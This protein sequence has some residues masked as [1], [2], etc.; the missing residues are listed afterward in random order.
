MFI[1]A[2]ISFEN[3]CRKEHR[4]CQIMNEAECYGHDMLN[5]QYTKIE[6]SF[7]AAKYISPSLEVIKKFDRPKEENFPNAKFIWSLGC[8]RFHM[9]RL[10]TPKEGVKK[11]EAA[12]ICDNLFDVWLNGRQIASDV[13]YMELCD[14]TSALC[15]GENNLHI[16]AYQSETFD[17]FCSAF[18]GGLR[19]TY[20]NGEI[21]EILTDSSFKQVSLVTFGDT[22]EPEGFETAIGGRVSN[23][24]ESDIHPIALRRSFYYMRR[25]KL[26]EMP[27]SAT[28]YTTALGCHEPYI[29]GK[30]VSD[31]FFEP[32]CTNYQHEYSQYDMLPF[33]N[34][35]ENTIGAIL[36]NGSYNCYSWGTLYWRTPELLAELI[37]EYSDGSVERIATDESWKCLPSPLTDNDIQYGER[38]DARLEVPEW[39]TN[40]FELSN[41]FEVS[42]RE[43]ADKLLLKSYPPIKAV[44]EY[45][46]T[47][48][49]MFDGQPLYDV[50]VCIAG[51]AK[52]V[53]KDLKAG[54]QV[55]IRYY[56]RFD[57]SGKLENGAYG[58]VI[59]NNDTNLDARC[60]GFV[61]NVDMYTAKGCGV[62]SYECRF[63]YTGFRYVVLEG[64]SVDQVVSLTAFELRNDLE[65]VGSI[66]T[67]DVAVNRIFNAAKRSWLNN[68]SNGPTDCPTREKNYWNGDSQLFVNAACWM[69]DNSDFLARWTDN[70]IKM[71]DG[72]YA[73]E[74]ET[75]VIPY[76][77][78]RF[79][80][81]KEILRARYP[82]M[83]KLIEK[84]Q[85]HEEMILPKNG[86]SHQYN[87]WLSPGGV[88]PNTEFF[89]GCWYIH[90]L[91]C[92][93]EIASILGDDAKADELS[94]RAEISIEEFNRRHIEENDYDAHCQCGIVLP[95]AFGIAPEEKRQALADRLSEYVREADYHTTTGFIGAR[96][97]FEVLSDYGHTDDAYRILTNPTDPSWLGMLNSGATAITESWYGASDPDRGISMSHFSLGAVAGWFFEYLGGIRVNESAPGLER[98]VLRPVMI[99]EIGHF[100]VNYKTSRGVI[101]T[102]WKFVDSK[103]EFHYSL[104]EGVEATVIL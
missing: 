94:K 2:D 88:T 57:R 100:A 36:G 78:Y 85:E 62:E 13:R 84:R 64:L 92:I 40:A 69:T 47:E 86:I 4:L 41:A 17:S 99:P 83:L 28:L 79:Y 65:M 59:Y 60:R 63:A 75:Y 71:H 7:D 54:Q 38:Y 51:R 32:F 70:G 102:E 91:K 20:E 3:H 81:D 90:M 103:P 61:R 104:P 74:D 82:K 67:D 6:R 8:V 93:S 16:R 96:F 30:R 26:K 44:K 37:V 43:C 9:F 18:S 58:A 35:G 46:L 21:E 39:S 80:G 15:D 52:V 97:L 24:N 76:A 25:F 98:V 53:L 34:E 56:E 27:K 101:H 68:I 50:G 55:R 22:E 95:I 5:K 42:A 89:G 29:N 14:I 87:D 45:P 66:E 23:L 48:Y 10:F 31:S 33:L 12:F 72:P 19:I 49:R 11:L 77:L 73:W 1:Y